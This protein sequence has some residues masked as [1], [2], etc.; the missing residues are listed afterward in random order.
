MPVVIESICVVACFLFILCKATLHQTLRDIMKK[1]RI[2]HTLFNANFIQ[3][4]Q[5]ISPCKRNIACL[6]SFH[7]V[8]VSQRGLARE[9]SQTALH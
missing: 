6:D 2:A 5:F 8:T 3:K 9:Y 1:D 7:S 4:L